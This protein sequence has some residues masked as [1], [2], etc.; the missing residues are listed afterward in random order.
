MNRRSA[1]LL[2]AALLLGAGAAPARE[3]EPFYLGLLR[4]GIAAA[5]RGDPEDAAQALQ[6]AC[7]GLLEE[8]KLLAECL[9]H[10][11]LAQAKLADANAF[12]ATFIRLAE[13]ESRF[14]AYSES[15]LSPATRAAFGAQA[16]ALVAPATLKGIPAFEPLAA[17]RLR[18]EL[19]KLSPRQ[20]RKELQRRLKETPGDPLLEEML[21]ELEG[22]GRKPAAKPAP[23]AAAPASPPASTPVRPA[24]GSPAASLPT[25]P[26][27]P[28]GA[29]PQV[30]PP[31][32]VASR[33][34]AAG[35]PAPTVPTPPAQKP[36]ALPPTPPAPAALPPEAQSQLAAARDLQAKAAT[37]GDLTAASALAQKVAD[38][39]PESSEAQF[40]VAEIAYRA[41]RFPEVITY[42]RR[43]GD[44]GASNPTLL[45][46]L[47]IA[48]YE[49]GD[50][51]AARTTLERCLQ[52]IQRTPFV[53]RYAQKILATPA[54]P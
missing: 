51:A 44:P 7:F 17:D 36:A 35:A 10:L 3:A 28:A 2:L 14:H 11:G 1:C 54:S 45:F 19:D 18:Q 29:A 49:T 6:I 41:S 40:L 25:A 53:E 22:G 26:K 37:A 30:A 9:V 8:P 27:P 50:R 39:H 12:R 13:I 47:A 33:P 21:A 23:Q 43:G 48:Q 38:A 4:E 24:P 32:P 16:A 20:R 31:A 15:A 34:A 42:M 46:Y 5:E 52:K